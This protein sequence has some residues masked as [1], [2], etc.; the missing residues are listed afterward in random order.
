MLKA[1]KNLFILPIVWLILLLHSIL[2][3][4][5]SHMPR[6]LSGRYYH[7]LS[8]LWCRIFVR[9][10]DVNL[11]L[12]HKNTHPL[13]KQYILI[14]NHPSAM[15]D[16][17]IPALFD[18]YPLAKEGVR[19]WIFLGRI[20]DYAGTVYVSRGSSRS[21]HAAKQALAEAVQSGKNI[22]IFPEGGCKG[23]RIYE[24][25]Q[26]GAFD[27]SLQTGVPVLPVFLQYVD[28]ATFE[29]KNES[30]IKKLWQIFKSNKNEVNYYVHDAFEAK[31]FS[32]KNSYSEYVHNQYL[33][34]Q[35]IYL[36]DL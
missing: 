8:R 25:F 21:R 28:Q 4:V 36:D 16:F 3:Y 33:E 27:I 18:V 19:D 22:V 5:L 31:D 2:L 24:Q 20:S 26:T 32:D 9:A 11:K 17:G 14:A 12:V 30:L 13:P 6:A 23:S 7:Y 29:W 35:K 15:E 1:I 34:W 10:L